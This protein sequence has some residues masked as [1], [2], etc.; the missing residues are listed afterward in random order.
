ML[1]NTKTKFAKY[2]GNERVSYLLRKGREMQKANLKKIRFHMAYLNKI[3]CHPPLDATQFN[4]VYW[5][6]YFN[7]KS[8]HIQKKEKVD[9]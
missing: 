1:N 8:Y 9:P 2:Y 7:F 4:T 6:F 3:N 5:M